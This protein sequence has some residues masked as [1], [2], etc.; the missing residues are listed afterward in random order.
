MWSVLSSTET[1][2]MTRLE[3]EEPCVRILKSEPS[4]CNESTALRKSSMPTSWVCLP[5]IC[6]RYLRHSSSSRN[7]PFL[8]L[9]AIHMLTTWIFKKLYDTSEDLQQSRS[10]SRQ[11]QAPQ[12]KTP[13]STIEDPRPVVNTSSK[14]EIG[15]QDFC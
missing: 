12:S 4:F 14:T 11:R 10:K 2:Q 13:C 3:P 8:G 7:P 5:L 15:T 6:C 9:K 1:E